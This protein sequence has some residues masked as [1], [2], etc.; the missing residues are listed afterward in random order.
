MMINDLLLVICDIDNTLVSS[1][2]TMKEKTKQV[3]N[4]LRNKGIYFGI[5]SGRSLDEIM[6]CAHQWGFDENFDVVIGINGCELWDGIQDNTFSYYK[7]QPEYIK[8]IYNEMS[9]FNSNAYMYLH[10]DILC[11]KKTD[12]FVLPAKKLTRN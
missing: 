7:L 9:K 10:G 8:E 6:K 12:K 11:N 1:H 4:E 3:I 5:A 2:K